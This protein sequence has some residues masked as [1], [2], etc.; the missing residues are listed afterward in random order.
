M[1]HALCQVWHNSGSATATANV[2]GCTR[3]HAIVFH[4][5]FSY[6]TVLLCGKCKNLSCCLFNTHTHIL[7][8]RSPCRTSSFN[9]TASIIALRNKARKIC[10]AGHSQA[11]TKTVITLNSCVFRISI[12]RANSN[13]TW[14]HNL[15]CVG[16]NLVIQVGNVGRTRSHINSLTIRNLHHRTASNTNGS[17]IQ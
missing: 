4:K 8:K 7:C 5:L 17:N 14:V 16:V 15:F 12:H 6:S 1:A 2:N 13:Q 3:V 9:R 10:C 11:N